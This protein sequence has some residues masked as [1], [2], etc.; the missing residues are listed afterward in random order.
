MINTRNSVL[1][2]HII[3]V[4]LPAI[5]SAG[6]LAAQEQV[7]VKLLDTPYSIE[8]SR[9]DALLMESQ[10]IGIVRGYGPMWPTSDHGTSPLVRPVVLRRTLSGM[11][12]TTPQEYLPSEDVRRFLSTQG[13]RAIRYRVI[14]PG[15]DGKGDAQELGEGEAGPAGMEYEGQ[16]IDEMM[17]MGPGMGGG[18]QPPKTP[19]LHE[20]QILASTP[21]RVEEIARALILVYNTQA[22]QYKE[23]SIAESKRE[24]A[25][26]AGLEAALQQARERFSKIEARYEAT[27]EV[28]AESYRALETQKWLIRVDLAGVEAR[29][30]AVEGLMEKSPTLAEGA[31]GK[32]EEIR[33]AAYVELAELLSKQAKVNEIL[34]NKKARDGLEQEYLNAKGKLE[35]SKASVDQCRTRARELME[36]AESGLYAHLK[37]END[38]ITIQPIQWR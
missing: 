24:T 27:E 21:Q 36:S 10:Y 1:K 17:Y 11:V 33:I 13:G 4:V 18:K 2:L 37:V 16:M 38:T 19:V 5:V 35:G 7:K 31:R 9:Q 14:E 23:G 25:R 3:A 20:F 29:K 30:K 32:L 34:Q 12:E 15:S 6:A 22:D 28:G 26:L 8:G